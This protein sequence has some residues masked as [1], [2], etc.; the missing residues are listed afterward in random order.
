MDAA[1]LLLLVAGSAA[2]AGAARRFGASGPL[3]LVIAGL[4][5]S[6]VPGVP[7]YAIDPHLVLPFV[8]P[9][10]LHTAALESSYLD[11]RANLRPVA[12]LSVGYVLFATFAVGFVVYWTI[13]A[14]PLTAALVLG[15][16]IAPPDAV[17]ATAIARRVGLPPRITTILQGESLVNDATAI[18][19]FRVALAATV[20]EGFSWTSGVTN[21]LLASVGGVAVGLALMVP[22]HW[23][24]RC[25]DEPLLQ[26]TLSLLTPF[27]AYAAAEQVH[28]SGVLAV[29]I[30]GL[31]IGHRQWQVDFRTR[32]QEEAVWR[33]VSFLLESVVFALIGLQLRVVVEGTGG[34]GS[35]AL[36]WYAFVVLAAVIAGRFVWVFP[37]TYLPRVLSARLRARDPSPPWTY[38][39]VISWAGMRGVVSLAVAFS[40]PRTTDGGGPFPERDLILFLTFVAVIG[41][42]IVHGLTLPRLV[43]LLGLPGR[44]VRAETLAEAQAQ[45]EA[46]RRALERFGELLREEGDPLPPPMEERLRNALERRQNAV[47]ERLGAVTPT[48]GESVDAVYRRLLKE[49]LAAERGVFVRMRDERRIDDE[50]LRTLMRR[51]D[52]VEAW[53]EVGAQE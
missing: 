23:L 2:I 36:A 48:R 16:V 24:R 40:I 13:P 31:Y 39:L 5:A 14:L 21:F 7:Q 30:V 9:P 29:V 22:L 46:S 19:A 45:S 42:L 20:G 3:M 33:M 12:L 35:G 18:T 6:F 1:P 10:L 38:P 52:L 17:A 44:D 34:Y 8:L 41:T 11:L 4:A 51:L 32:L 27:A 15:A 47:W 50:M 28:A 43:A 37:A 53:A 49:T 26:N 25:L